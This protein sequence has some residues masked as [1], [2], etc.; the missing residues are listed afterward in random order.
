MGSSQSIAEY[1]NQLDELYLSLQDTLYADEVFNFVSLCEEYASTGKGKKKYIDI[2]VK[3][4]TDLCN[5]EENDE[6]MLTLGNWYLNGKFVEQDYEKAYSFFEEASEFG[7]YDA[8][9]QM[10]F[11]GYKGL[12]AN[13]DDEDAYKYFV[14]AAIANN[15]R[16]ISLLGEMYLAGDYVEQ[17]DNIAFDLFQRAY[18]LIKKLSDEEKLDSPIAE[19]CINLASCYAEEI[20]TYEDKKKAMIY[21]SEAMGYVYARKNYHFINNDEIKKSIVELLDKIKKSL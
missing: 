5:Q 9:V 21:A 6:A 7:N 8:F 17:D 1:E 2:S 3:M 20:G 4:L 14:P 11:M 19:V 10:G 13:I 16:A 15:V 18:N 12:I